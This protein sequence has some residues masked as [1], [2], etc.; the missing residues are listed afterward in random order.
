MI[1][2]QT[3]T[4]SKW[5]VAVIYAASWLWPNL[6]SSETLLSCYQCWVLGNGTEQSKPYYN[7]QLLESIHRRQGVANLEMND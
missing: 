6:K 1:D 3:L 2:G 5:T 4:S 7:I